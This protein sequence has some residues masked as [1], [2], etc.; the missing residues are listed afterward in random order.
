M[1]KNRY[2]NNLESIK[3]RKFVFD[4][5]HLLYYKCRKRNRNRDESYINSLDWI[6]TK[7]TTITPINKKDNKCLQHAATFALN[8]EE[9]KKKSGK[10]NK[11]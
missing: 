9:I 8:Y 11:N 4:Y 1:L 3:N 7:S 10:N 6:K 2:Q 5:V